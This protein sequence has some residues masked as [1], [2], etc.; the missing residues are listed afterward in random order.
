MEKQLSFDQVSEWPELPAQGNV[1]TIPSLGNKP[2]W[3]ET[4]A[5]LIADYLRYF[6]FIT[7]HGTYIDGFSGPQYAEMDEAWA[8]KLVL[9][10]EPK[11]LR[12]FYLCE[13]SKTSYDA[14]RSLVEAQPEVKKRVIE[15][16]QGDF[17]RYVEQVLASGRISDAEAT[18]ALLDQRT[19]ECEWSTV[20][21]LANHKGA[22]RKIE[23]FYFFP[24]G[25]INRALAA[26]K[27]ETVL[28]RWWGDH[29]WR[30]LKDKRPHA[31][32][33]AMN[34][35]IRD[36]GYADVKSW[37]ITKREGGEGRVMYHM[38]HATDHNEAP[39][40]MYRAYRNL[41]ADTAT[42]VEQMELDY[43]IEPTE[44]ENTNNSSTK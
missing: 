20:T 34:K 43:G 13:L 31:Q 15:T 21:Q 7:K 17:N 25:W 3:T 12:N 14:L 39:K 22:G 35:K 37:P 32:V 27:D 28:E 38:I 23:L 18:F 33:E 11:W 29:S 36:L 24:T 44:L 5:K 26:Q 16:H 42:E 19:F 41:V 10:M 2:I 9:E 8:A 4:K 40:L 30:D 1:V 6:L